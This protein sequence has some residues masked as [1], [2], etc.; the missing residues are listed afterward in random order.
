MNTV[1]MYC[2]VRP[3]EERY[4]DNKNIFQNTYCALLPRLY[5]PLNYCRRQRGKIL[6]PFFEWG[7][8]IPWSYYRALINSFK[9]IVFFCE[10]DFEILQLLRLM[11]TIRRSFFVKGPLFLSIAIIIFMYFTEITVY[12]AAFA[13]R[14]AIVHGHESAHSNFKQKYH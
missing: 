6:N 12:K 9:R 10:G 7:E 1:C 5:N 13:V 4:S 8:K 14:V 3:R 11:F 2:C